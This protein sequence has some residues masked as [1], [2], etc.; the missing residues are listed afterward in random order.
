MK[1]TKFFFLKQNQI[2]KL[3]KI[4]FYFESFEFI[5]FVEAFFCFFDF[6]YREK[7]L[8][9]KILG[10]RFV[11]W[12]LCCVMCQVFCVRVGLRLL[13]CYFN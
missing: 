6:R 11:G 8:E 1:T 9:W 10:E 13:K 12:V 4:L 7:R 2:T 3:Y 5:L